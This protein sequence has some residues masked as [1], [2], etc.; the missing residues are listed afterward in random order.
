MEQTP[1]LLVRYRL[2]VTMRRF[3][4]ACAEGIPSGE[5]R[6]ELHLADGQ[7]AVAA[8]MAGTLRPG[9]WMV[10]THRSHQHGIAKGV[11]LEPM[12]AEVYERATGLSRGKGGHVHLFDMEHRFSVTGIVGSSLPVALGHAYASI[13]EKSN[14]IAVGITGDG[15]TNIGQFHETMNM[16]AIWKLPLVILVENNH[17]AISVPAGEVIA[18]RGI[19]ER[20]EAYG[21]WGRRVDGTDVEVVA[22]AFEEAADHARSG[23]GPALLETMCFRFRGHYEGD[24]DHYRKSAVKRRMRE[25]GDP[26]SIVRHRLLERGE[27][28][29]AALDD[30]EGDIA[31]NIQNILARVRAAPAPAPEE[32]FTDIFAEAAP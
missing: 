28:D 19:A 17:Y 7:E 29:E 13:L 24:T 22:A 5:L 21:A 20:A 27:A 3:E 2:M 6:G 11:P 10:S 25:E 4:E 23:E 8:G 9:D 1:A 12:M 31:A 30:L 18:G 32:A 14:D 16:A 15:G 26:L